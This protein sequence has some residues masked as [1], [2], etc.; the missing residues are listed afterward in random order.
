VIVVLMGVAGAGKS[1]VGAALAAALDWPFVDADDFHSGANV[2]K[3]R[4]G[5]P[6][7]DDD[8][9]PWL[10]RVHDR[11]AE[12]ARRGNAVLACSALRPAY[13]EAIADGIGDVRWVLL[14]ASEAVLARRLLTRTG[15]FAGPEL[16][17][18]QLATL[19]PP[20]DALV[21]RANQPVPAIVQELRR[22]LGL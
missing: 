10:A 12:T 7:T 17:P 16:L 3:M 19:E 22:A 1:T 6:L 18:T 5:V 11:I 14:E 2:D 21:I 13:R 9:A 15:H 20:A 8:R 4:R